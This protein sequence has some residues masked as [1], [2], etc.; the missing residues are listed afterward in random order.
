MVQPTPE[1]LSVLPPSGRV[2]IRLAD[3]LNRHPVVARS[4]NM[5]MSGMVWACGGRRIRAA[6]LENIAHIGPNDSVLLVANHRSFFD[7]FTILQVSYWHTRLP[8]RFLF[9][10]RTSFFYER[11]L[12]V[13]VNLAMTGMRMF[14]PIAR[15]RERSALNRFSL[16]RCIEEL[17]KPGTMLGLHPEGTR[18]KGDDPYTLLPGQP[19]VGKVALE[20]KDARVVPVFVVGMSNALGRELVHNWTAPHDHR[21]DVLFGPEVELSDLRAQGSRPANTKR[22]VDRC[23]DAI[24][25]LGQV[26]RGRPPVNGTA[27]PA[28]VG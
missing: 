15:E 13:V 11:P 25:K 20:A 12:G 27:Q 4:N 16:A 28:M 23:I 1:E 10:V 22:A 8:R 21:I 2:A 5:F 14:P 18:N 17:S 7:F 6:G 19:G 9:P 24:T 3:I 26:H